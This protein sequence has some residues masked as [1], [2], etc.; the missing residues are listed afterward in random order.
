MGAFV[1]FKNLLCFYSWV[2]NVVRLGQN[3]LVINDRIGYI[4]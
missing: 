4:Y 3:R 1:T 2:A